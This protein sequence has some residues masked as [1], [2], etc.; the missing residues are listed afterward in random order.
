MFLVSLSYIGHTLTGDLV[1]SF[2]TM[3]E[4]DIN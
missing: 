4:V 1:S 3:G 2:F